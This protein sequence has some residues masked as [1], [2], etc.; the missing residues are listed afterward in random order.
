[1][2]L[3]VFAFLLERPMDVLVAKQ[4]KKDRPKKRHE[5][6]QQTPSY[7]RGRIPFGQEDP[8]N[9]DHQEPHAQEGRDFN[10]QRMK[11][12]HRKAGFFSIWVAW[13][14]ETVYDSGR[15]NPPSMSRR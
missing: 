13:F 11:P 8:G 3:L 10:Y 6:Y 5:E 7:G 4:H 9:R 2:N 12:F 14:L 15:F 1:E